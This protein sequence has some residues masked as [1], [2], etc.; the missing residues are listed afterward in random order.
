M[1]RRGGGGAG[2][3]AIRAV[4]SAH[5]RGAQLATNPGILAGVG[6]L[7][8]RGLLRLFR[9]VAGCAAPSR[10]RCSASLLRWR[11]LGR[12]IVVAVRQAAA[13]VPASRRAVGRRGGGCDLINVLIERQLAPL[14]L[15]RAAR[16][17]RRAAK[18]AGRRRRRGVSAVALARARGAVRQA[19]ACG[20]GGGGGGQAAAGMVGSAAPHGAALCGAVGGRFS[21]GVE[22]V[23]AGDGG[24]G[25]GG[26]GLHPM[27][28]SQHIAA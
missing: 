27:P 11:L 17:R 2:R 18:A 20:S 26:F 24:E 22:A 28:V 16:S 6:A 1:L 14:G 12:P 8:T 13:V 3:R 9:S 21:G 23:A 19:R 7:A 15:R 25:D 5:H 10:P 4:R